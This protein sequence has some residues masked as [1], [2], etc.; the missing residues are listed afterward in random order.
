M[1][2]SKLMLRYNRRWISQIFFEHLCSAKILRKVQLSWRRSIWLPMKCKLVQL[3]F[4]LHFI[5][6]QGLSLKVLETGYF[7]TKQGLTFFSN[8][9]NS[10]YGL[11]NMSGMGTLLKMKLVVFVHFCCSFVQ[12]LFSRN[13]NLL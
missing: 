5:S 3:S 11:W 9:M 7:H 12:N 10:F 2:F 8:S 4:A 6:F 1:W 13:L